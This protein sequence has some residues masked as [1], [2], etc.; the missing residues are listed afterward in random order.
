VII[1]WF[2]KSKATSQTERAE[3]RE[4]IA[5]QTA[6]LAEMAALPPCPECKGKCNVTWATNHRECDPAQCKICQCTKCLMDKDDKLSGTGWVWFPVECLPDG[7]P[8]PL[9]SG[10]PP[11]PSTGTGQKYYHNTFTKVSQWEIPT[12]S[13]AI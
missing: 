7:T 12:E 9:S 4:R 11:P 8:P 6:F 5:F 2:D 1:K 13:G 10:A 3:A